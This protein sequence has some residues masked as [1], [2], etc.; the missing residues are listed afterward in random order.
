MEGKSSTQ[1]ECFFSTFTCQLKLPDFRRMT[2]IL[3]ALTLKIV[4]QQIIENFPQ[5]STEI[6]RFFNG[7][8]NLGFLKTSCF[9]LKRNLNF[10]QDR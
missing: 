8:Q 10:F 5:N 3:T 6:V 1:S 2:N 9:I 4:N 7:V